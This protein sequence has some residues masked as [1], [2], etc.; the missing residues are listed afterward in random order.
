V[1]RRGSREEGLPPVE[2]L[3][4]LPGLLGRLIAVH[5]AN[6]LTAEVL[7][8][9]TNAIPVYVG[10]EGHNEILVVHVYPAVECHDPRLGIDGLP[11]LLNPG[12]VRRNV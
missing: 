2:C 5:A 11:P 12:H 7:F 9:V 1:R 4:L 6:A 10:A 8:E 3:N